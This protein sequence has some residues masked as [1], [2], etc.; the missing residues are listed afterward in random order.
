MLCGRINQPLL[1]ARKEAVCMFHR[2]LIH[3]V[4]SRM[5]NQRI[6]FFF[7]CWQFFSF[8]YLYTY[9]TADGNLCRFCFDRIIFF[10][11]FFIFSALHR[12]VNIIQQEEICTH[13]QTWS[14][15]REGNTKHG[16]CVFD[17]ELNVNFCCWQFFIFFFIYIFCCCCPLLCFWLSFEK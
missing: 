8:S 7:L 14:T 17:N 4:S 13:W 3:S 9:Y 5:N 10:S 15:P 1:C 12:T 6:W 11:G 16:C 2:S